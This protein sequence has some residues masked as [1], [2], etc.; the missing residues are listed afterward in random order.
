MPFDYGFAECLRTSKEV[1]M[2]GR[3]VTCLV[4]CIFV[5]VLVQSSHY[6]SA[7]DDLSLR[8]WGQVSPFISGEAGSGSGAPD[9]NDA[10]DC[11]IGG[12]MEISW[13]FSNRFSFLSGIGYEN[14][15][16]DSH[17]GISF[18]D[19]EIVPVYLGGKFHIIPGDTRWDPYLRMDMGAAY[20]SS[21]DVSYH[22]LKGEYWD[23]SWVFLFDAG[24]GM[25][26][27]WKQWGA[28]LEIRA[29]YL[30]DP[31]SAMGHP[32]E[33]DSSWTLPISFGFSYYF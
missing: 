29:R 8:L 11:G 18:D 3:S 19:L 4:S 24:G 5:F 20:L 16:G 25:E 31:D 23:S 22:S 9:Y 28:F 13:R 10:F 12:G 6:V 15:D 1:K 7:E 33:A 21:V 32:S 14:Y 2:N 27:R 17:Q 26:Y 30:D